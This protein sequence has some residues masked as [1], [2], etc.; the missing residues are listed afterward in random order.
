MTTN[1]KCSFLLAVVLALVAF[2]VKAETYPDR[3]IRLIVPFAAGSATDVVARTISEPLSQSLGQPIVIDNRPGA[4]SIIGTNLI[5]KAEPDGYTIGLAPNAGLAANPAGLMKGGTPYD[6]ERD[7][8]YIS[9]V[10]EI[11]WVLVSNSSFPAD[12]VQEFIDYVKNS[13]QPISYGSGN[14]GGLAYMRSIIKSNGLAMVN[15]PYQST[16]PAL[17]ALRGDIF[18]VMVLDLA[19]ALP[20]IKG[21]KIKAIAVFSEQRSPLLPDVPSYSESKLPSVPDLPGW[22]ALVG[23]A[24]MPKQAIER[25]TSEIAQILQ[26]EQ[27]QK[28]LGA[29]GFVLNPTTPAETTNYQREQLVIWKKAIEEL[30]L[31]EY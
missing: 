28:T 27:V 8:E 1:R 20:Q 10:S 26:S 3:P 22:S 6:P 31:T 2:H 5:A 9:L 13:P 17:M 4:S 15:V 19:T 16:P 30:Q 25:L 29:R 14:V 24:G 18:P 21:G 23:P 12:T 11:S 7:F